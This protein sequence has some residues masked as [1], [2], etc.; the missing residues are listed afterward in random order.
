ME[1]SGSRGQK[2]A[3]QSRFCNL[4]AEDA[5]V[6]HQNK[7]AGRNRRLSVNSLKT[8]AAVSW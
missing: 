4:S 6:Y 1:N 7:S 2:E 8:Y 3:K 5:E